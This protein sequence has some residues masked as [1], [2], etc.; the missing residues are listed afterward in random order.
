MLLFCFVFFL[1]IVARPLHAQEANARVLTLDA[2]LAE[3]HTHSPLLRGANAQADAADARQDRARASLLPQL[4]GTASYQRTTANYVPRPGVLPTATT[5]GT[6]AASA[7]PL[8]WDTFNYY[9][10]GVAASVLLYDFQGSIDR[11]RASKET[12]R[13]LEER[14]RA[15]ALQVDFMVRDGFFR[16]RAQR[17]MVGVAREALANNQRHVDQI[18]AFVDVGTRPEIDLRQVRTDLANARVSLLQ[19]EN[20]AQIA[21]ATLQQA[22]GVGGAYDFEVADERLAPLTNEGAAAEVLLHEA[23]R[24]RPDVVALERELRASALSESASKGA[25]GPAVSASSAI[26]SGGQALDEQ[27]WNWNAGVQLNWPIIRGGAT[28]AEVREA[29]ANQRRVEASIDELR[30]TVRLQVEQ[31]RLGLGAALAVLEAA[32]EALENARARLALAEGRYEAGVGNVI[33]L[34]DAQVAL[35]S[36]EAQSVSAEYSLSMAR[37]QLLSA[38]GRSR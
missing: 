24:E 9:Q 12:R 8:S 26:N 22:M 7:R 32:G 14:A 27:R 6:Q 38:V 19:A 33:E 1:S 11:F 36:A 15:T 16:A 3:A 20:A 37:A 29:K 4:L 13:A 23:I 17:A 25:Y 35:T 21:K 34:G 10:L 2:A 18:Q 31:A 28:I 5:G 30:Q